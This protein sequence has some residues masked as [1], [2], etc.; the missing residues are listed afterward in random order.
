MTERRIYDQE[1]YAHFVTFSC[2]RR[3]RLLDADRAKACVL[4]TLLD[5]MHLNPVRA[6]FV[7]RAI[8]WCWSSARW[9][10]ERKTVGVPITWLE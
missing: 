3:A 2:Y 10:D 8:D 5:Y 1:R 4:G 9:Y 7:E 6:G